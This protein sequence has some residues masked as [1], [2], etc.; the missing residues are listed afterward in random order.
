MPLEKAAL[1]AAAN[2][3]VILPSMRAVPSATDHANERQDFAATTDLRDRCLNSDV[4]LG[5]VSVLAVCPPLFEQNFDQITPPA[6]PSGWTASQ[7]MNLSGAPFWVSSAIAS[8]TAPND[9]FSEAPGNILDNRLDTPLVQ[10][11]TFD[12]SFAFRNNFNLEEGFDGAVLEVSAPEINGGEFTDILDPSVG[13]KFTGGGYNATIGTKF[14]SPIAGRRAW[15]GNSGGYVWTAV[16]IPGIMSGSPNEMRLRF[17][18]VTDNSGASV[19]WRID[20]FRWDHNEC[21]PP[22]PTPA[23]PTPTASPTLTPSP[24]PRPT[25]GR[26]LN[27]STRLRVETGNGL[28]IAGFIITGTTAKQVAIRGVGPS[29]AAIGLSDVLPDPV[30]ELR[31][32]GGGLVTEN[33]NWQDDPAQ[34]AQLNKLGLGLTDSNESGI[35]ATLEPGAYTAILSGKNSTTGTG[36]VEVYD[37][38]SGSASELGNLSTRGLVGTGNDIMIGGFILG[39]STAGATNMVV[40]GI[41][42]SLVQAGLNGVLADPMLELRDS[43]GALVVANDNWQDDPLSAAE[44]SARGLAPQDPLESGIFTTLG[45]GAFTALLAGKGGGIGLALVEIYNVSSSARLVVTTATDSGQGSLRQAIADAA[46]SD[47]VDFDSSLNGQTI[48]LTSGELV[49]DKSIT[50]NGPA[51][52]LITVSIDQNSASW[53]FRIFHVMP[54]HKVTIRGLTLSNGGPSG[55]GGAAIYNDQGTL[56]INSCNIAD[57]FTELAGGG[58]YNATNSAILLINSTVTGNHAAG[59][60]GGIVAGGSGG[61]IY[62]RGMLE[63]RN[64]T[65]SDNSVTTLPPYP[66]GAGG[67]FNGTGATLTISKSTIDGNTAGFSG[68]GISNYGTL[69]LT[70]STV[71]DNRST[72]GGDGGGIENHGSLTI[73]NSTISS[74]VTSYKGFGNGGGIYNGNALTISNST[75]SGNSSG[76]FIGDGGGI[77]LDSGTLQINNTILKAGGNGANIFNNSGTVTSQGYNLSSDDGGG[78]LTA[79]G[80]VIN[81]D[82]LLGPLQNNGGATLTHELLKGSPAINAGDPNFTPPPFYDQRAQ[83]G[84]DRVYGGRLDI[85]SFEVQPCCPPTPTP[86]APR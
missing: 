26:A 43:N 80:D 41:G 7:G 39:H 23:P 4:L 18:L 62:N 72:L 83:P 5:C 67:I 54:G 37:A 11:S 12:W 8:D 24:T 21:N 16:S 38:D 51:P 15:S 86:S 10:V 14:N 25:P 1:T 32:S 27:L 61:G 75:I 34:A 82:P 46:D 85:G 56:T 68:G 31:D 58:I 71:S 70:D 52:N 42:P 73:V 30:L 66:G 63:I 36:L 77:Y 49:I 47:I 53:P 2:S 13:G 28:T 29:L 57:N 9:V 40:R 17:R 35:V 3:D 84:Y 76:G 50:I 22:S 55:V 81:T 65:I 69:S 33:D 44:L 60:I 78:F 20:T 74:N 59:E 6:L 79:T 64:S 19:G 48:L 45:P